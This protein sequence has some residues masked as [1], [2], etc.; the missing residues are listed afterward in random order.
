MAVTAA[1][2]ERAIRG[3]DF[4]ADRND[5]VQQAQSNKA[6]SDIIDILKNLPWNRFNSPIDVSKAFGKERRM[7][8]R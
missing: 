7:H 1:D 8:R 2:V 6:N 5:L 3:I 4:P